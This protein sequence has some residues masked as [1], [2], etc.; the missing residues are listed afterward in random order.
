V[1]ITLP[2]PPRVLHPN[3]R[4]HW[5]KKAKAVREYRGRAWAEA[6]RAAFPNPPRWAA[7]EVRATFY[8]ATDRRRDGDGATS[9][10][11]AAF[12]GI[13]DA[14]IVAD[15]AG[16]VHHP[17]VLRVDREAPRVEIEVTPLGDLRLGA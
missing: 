6:Y 11:K 4:A 5:A 8:F 10:L 3:G 9:S 12:D 16:M 2:L 17:P 7:A 14:G 15:D 1:R 13:A